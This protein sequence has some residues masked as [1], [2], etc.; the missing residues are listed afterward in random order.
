MKNDKLTYLIYI[1]LH[2][3][4]QKIRHIDYLPHTQ[5]IVAHNIVPHQSNIQTKSID[6]FID[7]LGEGK[8]TAFSFNEDNLSMAQLL[9]WEFETRNLPAIELVRFDGNPCK[10]PDFIQNFKSRV[11]DK[12]SFNDSIRMERLIS[13]LNGEAKWVVTSVGQSGIFYASAHKTLKRNFSKPAVLSYMKLKTALDL[14]QLPTN[15]YNGLRAYHQ[16]LKATVTWIFSMGYNAAIKSTESVTKAVVRLHK[17][18]RSV[19]SRL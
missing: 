16:T 7:L 5:Y 6:S 17:Y 10:W 11:H 8:E 15:D 1:S 2:H 9:Q 12:R 14:P 4:D 3:I 13:V 19:L 18:V